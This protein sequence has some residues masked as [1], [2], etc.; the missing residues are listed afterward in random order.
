VP[1]TL[2]KPVIPVGAVKSFGPFGSKYR[3]GEAIHKLDDDDWMVEVVLIESGERA[4]YRLSRIESDP[5]AE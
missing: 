2:E 5:E 3:V 4:E 1:S